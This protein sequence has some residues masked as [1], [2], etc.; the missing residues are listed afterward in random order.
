MKRVFFF[1]FI[2]DFTRKVKTKNKIRKQVHANLTAGFIF[3]VPPRHAQRCVVHWCRVSGVTCGY[4][5]HGGRCLC[6]CGNGA[7][8]HISVCRGQ[9]PKFSRSFCCSCQNFLQVS[10]AARSLCTQRNSSL[11]TPVALSVV[12]FLNF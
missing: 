10:S 3:C 12:S 7:S 4:L 2:H 11:I 1:S 6:V 9:D 5:G 8:Q